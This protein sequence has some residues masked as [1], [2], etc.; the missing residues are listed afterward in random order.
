MSK[1]APTN[2]L[3]TKKVKKA[4]SKKNVSSNL[5]KSPN[6]NQVHKTQGDRVL[7]LESQFKEMR[8]AQ[9]ERQVNEYIAYFHK[10]GHFLKIHPVTGEVLNDTNGLPIQIKIPSL[11]QEIQQLKETINFSAGLDTL[12]NELVDITNQQS[13]KKVDNNNKLPSVT[14]FNELFKKF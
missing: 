13:K 12:V 6:K 9:L 8:L 2:S 14:S 3:K 11:I 5:P 1:N 4:V 7:S 10:H